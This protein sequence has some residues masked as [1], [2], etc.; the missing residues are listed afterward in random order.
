MKAYS[1]SFG[2][3]PGTNTKDE[4]AF[5]KKNLKIYK[6]IILRD[7]KRMNIKKKQFK[8]LSVLDVGTGR[9][10]LIFEELGFKEIYV[11]NNNQKNI[12]R[13]KN[14]LKNSNS[15]IKANFIDLCS[16]KFSKVKKKFDLIYL[17]G[18]I[19]HVSD[20]KKAIDNCIDKLNERGLIWLYFYQFGCIKYLYIDLARKLIKKSKIS[21]NSFKKK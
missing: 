19:Q 7:L 21:I 2:G 14:F 8:D 4:N 18:I 11:I 3:P 6:K 16:V 13:L 10:A 12:K 20:Q 1:F 17:H 15:K 5:S 9:Q